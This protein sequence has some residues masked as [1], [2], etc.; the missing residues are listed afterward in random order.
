MKKLMLIVIVYL[1]L[2]NQALARDVYV[3]GHMRS[4]GTYVQPYH[5]SSPDHNVSNNYPTQGNI[6]PYTGQIGT[7]S[8]YQHQQQ[9][10]P[11]VWGQSQQQQHQR[12]LFGD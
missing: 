8:P 9:Q 10:L 5:R 6:N 7:V 1:A 3:Q 11:S 4:D 2:A 12:S